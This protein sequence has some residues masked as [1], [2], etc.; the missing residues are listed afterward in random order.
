M[1]AASRVASPPFLKRRSTRPSPRSRSSEARPLAIRRIGQAIYAARGSRLPSTASDR[2]KHARG[3]PLCWRQVCTP[4]QQVKQMSQE[5]H[6]ARLAAS[7]AGGTRP[8][9]VHER[10]YPTSAGRGSRR[11]DSSRPRIRRREVSL[12]GRGLARFFVCQA[13]SLARAF[14]PPKEKGTQNGGLMPVVARSRLGA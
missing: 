10:C 5:P 9:P 3:A 7:Q 11:S 1:T 2:L 12:S 8:P 6:P 13:P 4:A 14:S